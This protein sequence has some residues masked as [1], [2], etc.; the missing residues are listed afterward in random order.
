MYHMH[1][2]PL[3]ITRSRLRMA[4]D[5]LLPL[6]EEPFPPVQLLTEGT[7]YTLELQ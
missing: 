5:S 7:E 4:K 1:I 2:K 6:K 3:I